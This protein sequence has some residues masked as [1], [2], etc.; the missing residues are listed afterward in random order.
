MSRA[1]ALKSSDAVLTWLGR[2][3]DIPQLQIPAARWIASI[4]LYG[5]NLDFH[6]QSGQ[7]AAWQTSVTPLGSHRT[8]GVDSVPAGRAKAVVGSNAASPR[9]ER[10]ISFTIG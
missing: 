6:G 9:T 5:L 2:I 10:T 4:R 7:G 1:N 3:L 8:G